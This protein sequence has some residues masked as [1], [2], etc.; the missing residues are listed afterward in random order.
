MSIE[1]RSL[2][3]QLQ[4]M[5]AFT[6]VWFGQLVSLLGTGMSRFAL[7]IWAWQI[8]GEATA[9]TLVG[10]FS[11]APAVLL[12]PIAGVLVDRWN[13]KIV[14]MISDLAAGIASIAI[15][16]LYATGHLQV[17]HLYVTGAFAGAFESFQ[18]PSF[19]AAISTMVRKEHY[20]RAS[21]M[22]SMADSSTTIVAPLL[23][24][25]LL[26]AIGI[27]GILIID[28]VTFVF[29][30]SMLIFVSIPQPA[31]EN[32]GDAP[33]NLWQETLFGFRYILARPS[34]LGLQMTFLAS[35]LIG[36]IGLVLVA[37]MIL[38][39]TSNNEVM[40]GTVQSALGVGGLAG[41]V[42]LS[43]WGGPRRRVHGVLLGF[44]GMGVFG[45]ALMG[46][47][48]AL[49]VW[50]AG[51][52]FTTFFLPFVNGSNQAIW[53]AKVAP[54]VQGRVFAAR[55]V[56]AQMSGPLAMLL[57]GPLADRVFEP[58]MQR[59]GWL[60]PVFGPLVGTGPGAGMSLI[61]VFI[62]LLGAGVGFAGYGV[63][64]IRNA[65]EI[66]PDYDRAHETAV[67]VIGD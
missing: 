45:Q 57:A 53:Q 33:R 31:Q 1:T 15:L 6:L 17:W 36:T 12:S 50:L 58:A 67:G 55:R 27:S 23:A 40:L 65:E 60:A 29:G 34:L 21:G 46:S 66:L 30:V 47:G 13:R 10:F 22:L 35:N 42:L 51:A 54:A 43:T 20:A 49:P 41:G 26:V 5:R 28:I 4:G 18:F 37:P 24:G 7:T 11:F 3:P 32:P 62:G 19:S 39:R 44:V 56:L 16:V 8:T 2:R 14:M 38:A 52:F 59:S 9:L 48:H 25:L 61:M 64:V 63:P